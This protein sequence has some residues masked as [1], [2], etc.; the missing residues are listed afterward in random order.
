VTETER[1]QETERQEERERETDRERERE[2]KIR[3]KM[4]KRE[5]KSDLPAR[6]APALHLQGPLGQLPAAVKYTHVCMH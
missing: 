4:K 3:D 6:Q 2:R 5:E 1:A